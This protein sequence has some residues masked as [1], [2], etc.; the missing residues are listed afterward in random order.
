MLYTVVG[1]GFVAL[2]LAVDWYRRRP[3]SPTRFAVVRL[4][5]AAFPTVVAVVFVI[6]G[7]GEILL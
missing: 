5:L 7:F 1:I 4:R 3:R 6:A 2:G